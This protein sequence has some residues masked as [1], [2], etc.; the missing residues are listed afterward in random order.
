QNVGCKL[1]VSGAIDWFFEQEEMG[2]I[3]EDDCLP[4]VSFFSYCQDL[5]VR[6]RDDHRVMVVSGSNYHPGKTFGKSSYYFSQ[7]PHIWGWAS[8][9]RAWEKYDLEMGSYPEFMAE[10][11]ITD[12]FPDPLVQN[13]WLKNFDLV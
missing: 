9:R 13:L 4:D 10:D 8:W 2:I 11:K 6:Y 3:L 7:Y 1:G 12:L 5:L